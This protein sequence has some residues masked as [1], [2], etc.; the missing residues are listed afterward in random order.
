MV[1][2][3]NISETFCVLLSGQSHSKFFLP[4]KI[5]CMHQVQW[6]CSQLRLM[7]TV[8]YQIT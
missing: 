2:S 6:L 3:S 7:L 1:Q 8:V 5:F 4:G